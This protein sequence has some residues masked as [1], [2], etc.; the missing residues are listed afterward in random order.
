MRSALKSLMMS[1]APN[2]ARAAANTLDGAAPGF[3]ID[4]KGRNYLGSGAAALSSLLTCTNASTVRTSVLSGQI[5]TWAA[6]TVRFDDSTGTYRMLFEGARTNLVLNSAALV[7]QN[8]TTTAVAYVLSVYGTGSVAWSGTAT[9]SL[10]GTGAAN[11]VQSTFTPSAGTLTLTVTGSVTSA[12]FELG[13]IA[14]SYIPTAGSTVTV[15]ADQMQLT[16]SAAAVLTGVGAC[17]AWRGYVPAAVA[18]WVMMSAQA[19]T[20]MIYPDNTTPTKLTAY[21]LVNPTFFGGGSLPGAEGICYGWG[22]AGG[23]AA[24][25]GE[26]PVSCVA[27]AA[28]LTAIY[29]GGAAGLAAR[30]VIYLDQLVGWATADRPTSAAVQ[31]QARAAT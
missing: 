23:Y 15:T 30:Q 9:G 19:G 22:A 17:V 8:V 12:Q 14:T 7:T 26:V 21:G 13:T 11:R 10:A 29:I 28:T 6:N 27:R 5:V 25:N 2:Y 4:G 24:A 18:G 3:I 1:P 31:A 16:S 20:P